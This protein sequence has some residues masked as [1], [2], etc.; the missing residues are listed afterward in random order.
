MKKILIC[1]MAFVLLLCGCGITP[2]GSTATDKTDIIESEEITVPEL[3]SRQIQI[4]EEMGLPAQYEKLE[5]HQQKTIM[6]IEE[7]LKYLDEKYGTTFIYTG[8]AQASVVDDE[9]LTAYSVDMNI[10]KQTTL[11]V[12]EDG[13]FEDDHVSVVASAEIESDLYAWAL[14]KIGA[15]VKVFAYD[16]VTKLTTTDGLSMETLDGAH[17]FLT[18]VLEGTYTEQ[19]LETYASVITERAH[20][21]GITGSLKM[22]M[23][24]ASAFSEVT[25][26]NYEHIKVSTGAD[27][28]YKA[29]F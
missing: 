19:E 2:S 7:L 21:F 24:D 15:G 29:D 6:R 22:F 1:L 13:V 17:V 20:E 18:I 11:Y 25:I 16:C 26:E 27:V 14:T 12:T 5:P 8:Y 3:N 23:L 28:A 4:C 10:Y 9:W